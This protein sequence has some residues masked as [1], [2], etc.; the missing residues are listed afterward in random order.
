LSKISE[1]KRLL[2]VSSFTPPLNAGAGKNAFNFA[3]FLAEKEHKVTLLSLNRRGRLLRRESIKQLK[4]V[5]LLYF[6]HNLMTKLLSL[7]I[8]LPGYLYYV[9]KNEV[10]FIYGGNI[11]GFEF[12]ILAGRFFRKKVIYRST[13]F[14]DDDLETLIYRR[15]AGKIRKK[16]MR[17]IT[18]FFS[19]NPAFTQA[20]R[21]IYITDENVF[22]SAQGVNVQDF[23]PVDAKYKKILRTRLGIPQNKLI[24]VTIGYLVKRK[25]FTEIFESL[26]KLNIPFH[27][28]V[29]GNYSVP[30]YHYLI[31]FN[32]EMKELYSF[33]KNLL[34]K[35]ISFT[36]P[37]EN[38]N[39]YLQ[40]ADVFLLNSRREGF[41]NALLE[42]M[43]C[44]LPSIVREIDGIDGYFMKRNTNI[45]VTSGESN[46]I[47]TC[48]KRLIS[49]TKLME[50]IGK[51]AGHVIRDQASFEVLWNRLKTKLKIHDD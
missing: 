33:G 41:P 27:Y 36:G 12:I 26:N 46:E 16:I 10:V 20:W 51:N 3:S 14:G 5:R 15:F 28:L 34:G 37:L 11:I 50:N 7:F 32:P 22:E 43:A 13:M 17:G 24:I 45:L 18:F 8:I 1:R 6:N 30:E 48:I 38:V 21:N 25:G 4:I 39:E 2:F 42:A 29:L 40:A 47:L 9:A 31:H 44:G 23:S 35:S 19:I 49:G